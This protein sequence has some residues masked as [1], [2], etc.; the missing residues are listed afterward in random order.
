[1][2]VPFALKPSPQTGRGLGKG[3][4][5]K[6]LYSLFFNLFKNKRNFEEDNY[7]TPPPPTRP[8]RR[9]LKS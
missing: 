4:K 6:V 1:V 8:P 9:E 5:N 7:L 2:P 3:N